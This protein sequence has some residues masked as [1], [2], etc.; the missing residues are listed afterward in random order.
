MFLYYLMIERD[1]SLQVINLN[2]NTGKNTDALKSAL[3]NAPVGSK[4]QNL[5]VSIECHKYMYMYNKK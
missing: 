2:I 1:A 5:K 4:D 3:K